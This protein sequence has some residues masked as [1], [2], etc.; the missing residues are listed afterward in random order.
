MFVCAAFV[1]E[2]H[3]G[4]V[5]LLSTHVTAKINPSWVSGGLPRRED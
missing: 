2:S 4:G 5:A 1:A 3:A